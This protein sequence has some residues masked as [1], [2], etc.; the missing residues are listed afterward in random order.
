MIK[1]DTVDDLNSLRMID[2][3][4]IPKELKRSMHSCWGRWQFGLLPI[5][6]T[7]ILGLPQNLEWKK[8][9]IVYLMDNK[10]EWL[11]DIDY[12]KV[13]KDVCPG[14][15][16][17]SLR[18][19]IRDIRK[20]TVKGEKILHKEPL[21]ELASKRIND[22]RNSSFLC[23]ETVVQKKLEHACSIVKV[24]EDFKAAKTILN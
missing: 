9:V 24:Y 5:L 17:H 18:V 8:D 6:R 19:F 4:G 13:V 2:C 1:M 16:T 23:D 14:Q 15:T 20:R 22:P 11:E 10:I 21:H 7:H 3:E 12:N